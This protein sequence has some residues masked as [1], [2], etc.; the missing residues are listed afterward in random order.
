MDA[1][2]PPR[3]IAKRATVLV[4]DDHPILLEGVRRLLE[5][6]Y[7]IVATAADGRELVAAT[8]RLS[9]DIVL[10]DIGMPLLNGIEAARL[11][12]R[13]APQVKIV[14]LTQQSHRSY[15]QE[16]FRA[17][18]AGYVLK[19]SAA[20]ELIRSLREVLQSRY[21]VSPVIAGADLTAR[22]DPNKNPSDLFGGALTPRQREV[23]QL[24]AEGKAAKEI[25][26][27]VGI[28]VKTVE[29]H[30]AAI[31]EELGLRTTAELTRY[32]LQHGIIA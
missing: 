4:A 6:E 22:L 31:M 15:V 5:T 27:I 12:K 16:A 13:N 7:D 10:M 17:G 18:A 19:Q 32:A 28:S 25:A 23:L 29:F 1:G 3:A 26:G 9:P 20:T 24:I 21:Y 2:T 14:F 8:L 11:I 30:K